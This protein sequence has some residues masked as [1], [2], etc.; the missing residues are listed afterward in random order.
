[1]APGTAPWRVKYPGIQMQSG[2][3]VDHS[4]QGLK[5]RKVVTKPLG[6]NYE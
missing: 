2:G 3:R 5:E 1:M 4:G 6:E